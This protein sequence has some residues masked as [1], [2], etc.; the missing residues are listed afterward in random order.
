MPNV[1]LDTGSLECLEHSSLV[2]ADLVVAGL[3]LDPDEAELLGVNQKIWP[4]VAPYLGL[5][6]RHRS[7]KESVFCRVER[8][9]LL[10]RGV[11]PEVDVADLPHEPIDSFLI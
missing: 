3:Y 5:M 7:P 2:R 10:H 8:C 1:D 6:L 9:A 4:P 11:R